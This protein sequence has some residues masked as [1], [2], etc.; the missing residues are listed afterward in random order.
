MKIY[1][2]QL[3][4]EKQAREDGESK[5]KEIEE[6]LKFYEQEFMKV[7]QGIRKNKFK[8]YIPIIHENL[9]NLALL[10]FQP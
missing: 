2:D 6:R 3:Q 7:Q 4:S 1:R 8:A 10:C 9:K 5:K